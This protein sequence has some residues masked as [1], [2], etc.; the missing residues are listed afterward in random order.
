MKNITES[1]IKEEV[2]K[3]LTEGVIDDDR[4]KFQQSV[5]TSVFNNYETISSDYDSKIER[6]NI[7]VIWKANFWVNEFGFEN[8]NV[9]IEGIQGTYV[10]QLFNK[11][12]QANEQTTD[13]DINEIKWKFEV[14]DI[15]LTKG[16]GLYIS[17]LSF[18]FK[19]NTCKVTF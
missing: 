17:G 7:V 6:S 12:S 2:Q 15:M 9:S 5:E 1:F 16:G 13:K 8:F 10:L 19:T 18:D 11:Q 4:F 14:G 3:F